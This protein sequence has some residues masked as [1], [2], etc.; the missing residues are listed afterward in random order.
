MKAVIY[1]DVPDYQI[2]QDVT[3]YFQDTTIKHGKCE[4]VK[5][6]QRPEKLLPCICGCK[7]R[8]HWYSSAENSREILK[9]SK[10]GFEVGGKNEIDVHKKWNGAVTQHESIRS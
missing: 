6:R 1:L 9:C 5:I 8:E 7:R 3:V 2:G 10:C 4:A